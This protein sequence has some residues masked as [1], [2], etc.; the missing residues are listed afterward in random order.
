MWEVEIVRKK[1]IATG[2]KI[3][4]LKS[5]ISLFGLFLKQFARN[6]MIFTFGLL[7]I[8]G[9]FW[10]NFYKTNNI[11]WNSKNYLIF[12]AK[13]S[14]KILSLLGLFSIWERGLF[15]TTYSQIWPF[16]FFGTGNPK[17]LFIA[18]I[19]NE[20]FLIELIR[21]PDHRWVVNR[22]SSHNDPSRS[23]RP[24]VTR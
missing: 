23:A 24:Q 3:C 21:S 13:F 8:F 6:K 15:E 11:L 20:C 17:S 10:Q 14:K 9:L 16:L 2:L 19:G 12:L 5:K 18:K 22:A 7:E 4:P 1:Q